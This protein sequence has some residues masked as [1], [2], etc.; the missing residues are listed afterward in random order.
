MFRVKFKKLLD[1]LTVVPYTHRLA[2]S[3]FFGLKSLKF[4]TNI[5]FVCSGMG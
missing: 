1:D 2:Y 3:E 5:D 4:V